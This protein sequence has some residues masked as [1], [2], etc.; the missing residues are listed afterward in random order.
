MAQENGSKIAS[1]RAQNQELGNQDSLTAFTELAFL[2]FCLFLMI[3]GMFVDCVV[4]HFAL[5]VLYCVYGTRN[6]TKFYT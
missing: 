3:A 6:D 1:E 5:R 2:S 4:L